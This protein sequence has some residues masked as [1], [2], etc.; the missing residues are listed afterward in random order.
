MRE[1]L[2]IFRLCY[3]YSFC[4]KLGTTLSMYVNPLGTLQQ[5]LE[6]ATQHYP[7]AEV[8]SLTLT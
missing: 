4:F 7:L 2:I 8:L 6:E 1:Q 5:V 3:T